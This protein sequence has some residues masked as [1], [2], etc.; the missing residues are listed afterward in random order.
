[1]EEG[2][3]WKEG[4]AKQ[5]GFQACHPNRPLLTVSGLWLLSKISFETGFHAKPKLEDHCI[6]LL[7]SHSSSQHELVSCL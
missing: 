7:N 3:F 5:M 1:M 4:E 6:F 2:T